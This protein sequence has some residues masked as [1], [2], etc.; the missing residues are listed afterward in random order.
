[1]KNRIL[2]FCFLAFF[3]GF[4][5]LSWQNSAVA[6]SPG[7][8]K[9]SLNL[10]WSPIGPDNFPGRTRTVIF[11]S[12][13]ASGNTLFAAGVDGGIWKSL[14]YG[15]TWEPV[16]TENQVVP[17]VTCMIQD[18][19][20]GTIYAGTGETFCTATFTNLK[21]Y[22]YTTGLM[23]NGLWFSTDGNSFAAMS[24]TQPV[25]GDNTSDWAFI[26]KLAFDG[27]HNR[28]Y[29]ATNTGLKYQETGGEW[30]VAKEGFSYEVK[31]SPDGTLLTEVDG[32]CYIAV[33]GDLN[34]LVN[35][36]TG[37]PNMLPNTD[38]G[39]VEFAYSITDQNVLYASVARLSDGYLMN[40]YVT[41]DK[42]QNWSI[43]FPGNSSFDP[44]EGR[45]CYDQ[46]LI[47]FPNDPYQV[48]LGGQD[49]WLGKKYQ[50]T[51]YYNW[52][53][54]SFGFATPLYP[55]YIPLY[56]HSY[57]F[58]PNNPT[59]DKLI[60]ASD[61]G[62]STFSATAG[63]KTTNKNY[64]TSQVVSV[65]FTYSKSIVIGG[66]VNNGTLLIDGTLNTPQSAAQA[67]L[68][69]F[70]GISGGY[71]DISVIDPNAIIF[72]E[73]G[74]G[75]FGSEDRGATVSLKFPG[76]ITN[77][78]SYTPPGYLWE[79]F[80]YKNSR[81]SVTYYANEAAVEAG[82]RIIVYS[83]NAK[84]PFYYTVPASIPQGDSIRVQDIIQSRFFSFFTKNSY[85]G[86]FMTKDF[87]QFTKD[88]EWFLV[89]KIPD[90]VT[91]I[92]VSKDLNYLFAGT[93]TGKIYRVSNLA[94]AYNYATADVN[95]PTT[96]VAYE[97]VKT[98]TGRAITSISISQEDNK[99]VALTMGGYGFDDY[100]YMTSNALDSVP[101]FVS[102]QGNLPKV[103]V[104]SGIIEMS[105]K[106]T[107]ILGT[108]NGIYST[109][110]AESAT[111]V[112]DNSGMGTTPVFMLKQQTLFYP[113]QYIN[114]NGKIFNYPGVE[115]Y[116]SIFAATYGQGFFIDTT[117]YKPVGIEPVNG[118]EQTTQS[119]LVYPN[120]VKD[121]AKVSFKLSVK[122]DVTLTVY[123]IGGRIVKTC[124][125][126]GLSS[127][128]HEFFID[129]SSQPAG[130]YIIRMTSKDGNGYGKLM[131]TN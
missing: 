55:L 61:G 102:I 49:M 50:E 16:P 112:S 57:S 34:N 29:A 54:Q 122:S 62:V 65:G 14:N 88:P 81:D 35:L 69:A 26:N 47:V 110:N 86:I 117:Y 123:D 127:G 20:T 43:I 41:T 78:I 70:A 131:K 53:Q 121:Q 126:N 12:R 99:R 72:T 13:D 3:L 5:L 66:A 105:N 32:V 91:C 124:I 63:F 115:N 39:R 108:D 22:L 21:E 84:F 106:N 74:G 60:V 130:T 104:Y 64:N 98:F 2:P 59:S 44:F 28:L 125:Q 120:P 27:V 52:E 76:T 94:L 85:T 109:D 129:F 17:K 107:I 75:L 97:L 40:V 37:D 23:G 58:Q 38:V 93:K 68:Q 36:S 45:G 15:L 6:G 56:H 67:D 51:G 9:S 73:N 96:I 118:Q 79:S 33:L 80:D 119:L 77:T 11:D 8:G 95:S 89:A 46:T 10:N 18:P 83:P 100:V 42:G 90:G 101:T 113:Y 87:L 31:V 4:S 82:Q 128:N 103:P 25:L 116:G 71:A 30:K 1:M 114:D 24:G 92:A 48:L 7:T 111:W 19:S